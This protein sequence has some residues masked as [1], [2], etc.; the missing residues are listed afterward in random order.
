MNDAELFEAIKKRNADTPASHEASNALPHLIVAEYGARGYRAFKQIYAAT[1]GSEFFDLDALP[2][3][4][5]FPGNLGPA[6]VIDRVWAPVSAHI[7]NFVA[8]LRD[9]CK[10]VIAVHRT[11]GPKNNRGWFL[12]YFLDRGKK[13]D[14]RYST[15][16]GRQ[17][18][19]RPKLNPRTRAAGFAL[20]NSLRL[21]YSVH[22]G[23]GLSTL[24]TSGVEAL[25]SAR[26]LSALPRHPDLLEV[27]CDS[28]G[29]RKAYPK[30][31]DRIVDW[32]RSTDDQANE[33]SLWLLFERELIRY[34]T[35]ED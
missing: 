5:P 13:V 32:D 17:T 30:G 22:N 21:F 31:E 34:V 3:G 28:G 35:G 23:L 2:A 12:G 4:C 11:Q 9:R 25:L 10:Y 14:S 16:W 18:F 1:E 29:N 15:M 26:N 19:R 24:R 33:G 20:P 6:A 27:Y 8:A 7:P